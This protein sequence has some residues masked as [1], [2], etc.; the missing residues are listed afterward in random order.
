M[1]DNLRPI[2]YN[3]LIIVSISQVRVMRYHLD[4]YYNYVGREHDMDNSLHDPQ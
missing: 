2:N 4:L 3:I 1:K